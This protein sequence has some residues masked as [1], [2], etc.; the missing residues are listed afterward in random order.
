[1]SSKGTRS[2][3]AIVAILQHPQDAGVFSFAARIIAAKYAPQAI[4][5]VKQ[6]KR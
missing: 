2:F 1:V 3:D 5:A 4:S 6:Q